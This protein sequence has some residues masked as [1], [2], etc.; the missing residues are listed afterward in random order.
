MVM[1][2]AISWLRR[3]DH[4]LPFQDDA[5][6]FAHCILN[7]GRKIEQLSGCAPVVDQC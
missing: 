1:N 3:Y 5:K 6:S 4:R 7:L 2:R